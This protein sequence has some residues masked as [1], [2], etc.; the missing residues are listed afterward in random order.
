MAVC[1]VRILFNFCGVSYVLS[2]YLAFLDVFFVCG[3]CFRRLITV[4]A[5][6]VDDLS[7]LSQGDLRLGG[8][9]VESNKHAL[10]RTKIGVE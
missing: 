1:G 9:S 6:V 2:A 8:L 7:D 5:Q 10:K 4:L 3:W